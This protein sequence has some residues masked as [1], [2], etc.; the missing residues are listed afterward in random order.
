MALGERVLVLEKGRVIAQGLPQEV[1]QRPQLE[2]VAQLAGFENI[3]DC[4]VVE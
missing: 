4:Q 3:F 1:L 2:S